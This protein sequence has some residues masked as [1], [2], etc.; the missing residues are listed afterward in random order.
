MDVSA[1]V[2]SSC[3]SLIAFR[4]LF[5]VPRN[6]TFNQNRSYFS[7]GKR[8]LRTLRGGSRGED[9]FKGY[10]LLKL[11]HRTSTSAILPPESDF[12]N[13]YRLRYILGDEV[14]LELHSCELSPSI[15][16]DSLTRNDFDVGVCSLN[17]NRS[18]G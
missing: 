4:I 15:N 17:S 10:S 8:G 5:T 16:D 13:H 14:P 18:S 11:Q 9:T 6:E 3:H 2:W 7:T 1:N 12:T